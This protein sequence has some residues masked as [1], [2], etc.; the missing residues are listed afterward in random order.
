LKT[1]TATDKILITPPP[2]P[3][4][5]IVDASISPS[6]IFF[7]TKKLLGGGRLVEGLGVIKLGDGVSVAVSVCGG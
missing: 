2:K 4:C 7:Q 3:I 6:G 5:D 1:A